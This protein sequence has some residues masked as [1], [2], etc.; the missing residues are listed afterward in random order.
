MQAYCVLSADMSLIS[1]TNLCVVLISSLMRLPRVWRSINTGILTL[2]SVGVFLRSVESLPYTSLCVPRYGTYS[3]LQALR[4]QWRCLCT[5]SGRLRSCVPATNY[6]SVR[7]NFSQM[8]ITR[9]ATRTRLVWTEKTACS[10][11]STA[12]ITRVT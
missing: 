11:R 8:F 12:T 6:P 3:V 4:S 9:I 7:F 2:S 1:Y 5:A 10:H